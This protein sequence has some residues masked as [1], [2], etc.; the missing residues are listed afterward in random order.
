[1]APEHT[2]S[3]PFKHTPPFVFPSSSS[4]FPCSKF[5]VSAKCPLN[6]YRPSPAAELV[7]N[8]PLNSCPGL[9]NSSHASSP[10]PPPL[11]SIIIEHSPP[12]S[13]L[14]AQFP[15]NNSATSLHQFSETEPASLS[16]KITGTSHLTHFQSAMSSFLLD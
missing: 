3:L 14:A 2:S 11:P 1:M 10:P 13:Q 7:Q 9:T 12:A 16:N 6:S 4:Q 8:P 15:S 5:H